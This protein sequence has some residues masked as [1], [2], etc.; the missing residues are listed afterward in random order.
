MNEKTIG[1]IG[2]CGRRMKWNPLLALMS[3][4]N[5]DRDRDWAKSKRKKVWWRF[6]TLEQSREHSEDQRKN[7]YTNPLLAKIQTH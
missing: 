7:A 2:K 4:V 3:T 5:F 6:T 1:K